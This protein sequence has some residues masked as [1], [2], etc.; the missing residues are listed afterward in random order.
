[1]KIQIHHRLMHMK[2]SKR[3]SNIILTETL[4]LYLY[5]CKGRLG[6]CMWCIKGIKEGESLWK[7]LKVLCC[8][9]KSILVLKRI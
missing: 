3:G 7:G 4:L 5:T 9:L 8:G 1:M 6:C 2:E